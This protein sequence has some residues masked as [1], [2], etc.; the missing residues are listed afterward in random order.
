MIDWWTVQVET[1]IMAKNIMIK[2][3]KL[4]EQKKEKN[5]TL[6]KHSMS[7][8]LSNILPVQG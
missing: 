3:D 5:K 1:A 6:L 8:I 2:R 7:R 4:Y